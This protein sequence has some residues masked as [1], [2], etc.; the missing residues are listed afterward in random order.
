MKLINFRNYQLEIN[1]EALLVKPIRDLYNKDLSP[2]KEDFITQCSIIYFMADPRSSYSDIIDL[3]ERFEEIKKQE[4]LPKSYKISKQLQA[5]IDVYKEMTK[6]S[7]SL[8]L[9]D[10]KV[11]IDKIRKFLREIDLTA[12]DDKGKPIYPINQVAS[13]VKMV[14]QLAKDITEAE[15]LVNSEIELSNRKRG[16]ELG[17]S[18]FEE[19]FKL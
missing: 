12:V 10:T 7:A 14:P 16:G 6:T 2:N 17:K 4:G 18:M 19:G 3:T 5:A 1:D 8:L 13:T 11:A 15:R 9:E